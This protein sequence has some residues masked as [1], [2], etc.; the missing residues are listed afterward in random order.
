MPATQP[1]ATGATA[2]LGCVLAHALQDAFPW[3]KDFHRVLPLHGRRPDLQALRPRST[4]IPHDATAAHTQPPHAMVRPQRRPSEVALTDTYIDLEGWVRQCDSV[5]DMRTSSQVASTSYG[6]ADVSF[7]V[8]DN[9]QPQSAAL[10]VVLDQAYKWK[11]GEL[12]LVHAHVLLRNARCQA[13]A[14]GVLVVW[15]CESRLTVL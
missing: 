5:T 8:A 10:T 3:P 14:G 12:P 7:T 11:T 1:T 2:G 13:G 6:T 9:Q 15:T 4:N